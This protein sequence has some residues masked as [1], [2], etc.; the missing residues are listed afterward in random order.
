MHAKTLLFGLMLGAASVAQ[1]A[2]TYQG[3]ATVN[4]EAGGTISIATQGSADPE[5]GTQTA[6]ATFANFHPKNGQATVNGTLTRNFARDGELVTVTFDGDLTINRGAAPAASNNGNGN[7]NNN[8]LPAQV[9]IQFTGLTVER[10][11]EHH[12]VSGTITV[13][14]QSVDVGNA[15]REL[16]ALLLGLFRT[17]RF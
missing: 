3:N 4:D 16:R 5:A 7:G 11:E 17:F 15:P 9:T 6:T 1:A 13:N 10:G 12:G 8:A 2:Y 14:G